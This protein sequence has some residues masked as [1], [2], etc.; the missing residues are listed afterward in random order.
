MDHSVSSF[1]PELVAI[2]K[3]AGQAILAVYVKADFGITYKED[4]SPLTSADMAAHHLIQAGLEAHR[5]AFPV[6]SEESE[7]LSFKVRQKWETCWLVDPLDG[8]R[9]FIKRNDDFTVNIALIQKGISTLGVVHAPALGLT[10]YASHEDGAFKQ[11]RE[12]TPIQIQVDDYRKQKLRVV[13]SRSHGVDITARLLEKKIDYECLRR[14][15]S[16]KLCLVAEGAAHLYPRYGRTMEWDTAAADCVVTEAGGSVT[17]MEGNR[18]RYNK[19]D[20]ANPEFLVRGNPP[21]PL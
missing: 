11:V 20:L 5:P 2:A 9:E 17:D 21:F 1:L 16:L 19:P 18:L 4:T 3:R 10:Y 14:G 7:A 6:I 15:S 12:E 13:I 8:T